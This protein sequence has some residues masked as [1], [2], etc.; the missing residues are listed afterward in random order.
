MIDRGIK[1]SVSRQCELVGLNRSCFYKGER[2]GA[3]QQDVLLMNE[4]D[5]IYTDCPFYG[6]RRITAELN[7][8][9]MNVNRKRIQRLMRIMGIYGQTPGIMTSRAHPEHKKYPYLLGGMTI[10][11]PNQVWCTDITYIPMK[12]GFSYLVAIM[13]WYSRKVF[14]WELSNTL[15]SDF[16]VR[17]LRKAIA[18]HGKPEVFNSDQGC[19]FTSKEFTDVLKSEKILISM[20]GKG[21]CM[22][23]IFIERLWWSVKY[24]KIYLNDYPDMDSLY[25]G[26]VDYFDF[27]N[28]RR[29]HESLGY[30]TPSEIH[31]GK[32][33][34]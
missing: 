9:G 28:N 21:R 14:T 34:A 15:D 3:K 10:D 6:S 5:R 25:K 24:E 18:E 17:A 26:I 22:D 31:Q 13:D 7:R 16:C 1:L 33:A 12:H 27:Y 11:R 19:Q 2:N 29:P 23:N 32:Q 4:I 20:D 8:R 30:M